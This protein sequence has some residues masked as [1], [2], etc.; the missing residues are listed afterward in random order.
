VELRLTLVRGKGRQVLVS[1]DYG[2]TEP[3]AVTAAG[4]TT[5]AAVVDAFNRLSGRLIGEVIDDA[6]ALATRL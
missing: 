4:K 6:R 3:T 1:G 5:P 2:G